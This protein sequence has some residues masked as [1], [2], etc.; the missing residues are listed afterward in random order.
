MCDDSGTLSAQ[1]ATCEQAE[2]ET[3]AQLARAEE[4]GQAAAAAEGALSSVREELRQVKQAAEERK[5]LA[6]SAVAPVSDIWVCFDRLL[7]V[8][9]AVERE[10]LSSYRATA[11]SERET[12]AEEKRQLLAQNARLMVAAAGGPTG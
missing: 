1:A 7:V 11:E 3:A 5:S 2:G 6:Q 9:D 4:A 12:F 8:L 10:S